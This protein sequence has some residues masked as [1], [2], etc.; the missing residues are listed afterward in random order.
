MPEPIPLYVD[1]DGTLV[2]ADTLRVSVGAWLRRSPLAALVLPILLVGGRAAFK[3]RLAHRVV[4]DPARLPWRESVLAFLRK[5]RAGGRR[6]VLATAAHRRIA[7]AVAVHCGLFDDVLA[8][9]G[10]VNLKGRAKLDAIRRHAVGDFA[11]MGDSGADVP[12]LRAA[13]E[14]F[15][16]HPSPALRRAAASMRVVRVFE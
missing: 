16:V 10:R 8:S 12:V 4:P 13:R 2:A 11:Y 6:L 3:E 7:E 9:S 14:A 1:L 5:E 15:L